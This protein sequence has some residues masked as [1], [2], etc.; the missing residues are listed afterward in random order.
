[1]VRVVAS[2]RRAGDLKPPGKNVDVGIRLSGKV[3]A[4]SLFLPF[5]NDSDYPKKFFTSSILS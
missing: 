3:H 5:A 1:M 2:R 4:G